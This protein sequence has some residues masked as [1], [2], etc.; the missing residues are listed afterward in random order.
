MRYVNLSFP[1]LL[2]DLAQHTQNAY[3][4]QGGL[5]KVVLIDKTGTICMSNW[6]PPWSIIS[7]RA[8]YLYIAL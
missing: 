6:L 3:N 1:I 4:D 2:D 8:I 5:A 7:T